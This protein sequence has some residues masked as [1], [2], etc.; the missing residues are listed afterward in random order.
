QWFQLAPD[1]AAE[2]VDGRIRATQAGPGGEMGLTVASLLPQPAPGPV[3]RGQKEPEMQGWMS[4]R[5][6]SLI[7]TPSFCLS[8]EGAAAAQFATLFSFGGSVGPDRDGTG[9][10][11]A[12]TG[13]RFAWTDDRGARRLTILRDE[14]DVSVRFE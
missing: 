9:L 2:R 12:A 5:A 7:P 14:A 3:I 10:D 8:V 11:E 1:W 13:G 4:D 6:G